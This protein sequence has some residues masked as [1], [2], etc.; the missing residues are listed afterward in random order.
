MTATF[1]TTCGVCHQSLNEHDETTHQ[2][3]FE[4]TV[5]ELKRGLFWAK[6]GIGMVWVAVI[7]QTIRTWNV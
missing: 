5:L 4:N 2:I 1:T 7:L 6:V 3:Y